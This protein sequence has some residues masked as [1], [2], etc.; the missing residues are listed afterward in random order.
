MQEGRCPLKSRLK[1]TRIPTQEESRGTVSLA[2]QIGLQTALHYLVVI[3][4]YHDSPSARKTL[5][6]GVKC[7]RHP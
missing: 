3:V 5:G 4:I 2:T 7:S 1:F 6:L